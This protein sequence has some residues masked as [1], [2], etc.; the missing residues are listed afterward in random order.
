LKKGFENNPICPCIFII[1]A[2]Y[3]D[4]LN[5]VETPKELIKTATYLKKMI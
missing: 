5:L 3:V 2:I 4:D 1:V